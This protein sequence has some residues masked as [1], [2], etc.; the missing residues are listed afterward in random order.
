M[1]PHYNIHADPLDSA[2]IAGSRFT[3][4]IPN[5]SGVKV[6]LG[7][8]EFTGIRKVDHDL[9]EIDVPQNAAGQKL[10]VDAMVCDGV[11]DGVWFVKHATRRQRKAAAMDE[12]AFRIVSAHI[13][14]ESTISRLQF[15]RSMKWTYGDVE[16]N[17]VYYH[18]TLTHYA[19]QT[20]EEFFAQRVGL[21][22]V[23]LSRVSD[24]SDKRRQELGIER[25]T[26]P[27]VW[28]HQYMCRPMHAGDE[29]TIGIDTVEINATRIGVRA[30]V[31]N[32]AG[33]A[34]VV[35]WVR[36]AMLLPDRTTIKIPDWFPR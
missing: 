6:V 18:P 22:Y 34:A 14:Q 2:P 29:F 28:L 15:Q 21:D 19:H 5:G 11:G 27:V 35:M 24:G 8:S 23:D 10:V 36:A 33:I 17:G 1:I 31:S 16:N 9:F 26:F 13:R 7:E 30:Y 20:F 25:M 3:V 4:S 32:S 12:E